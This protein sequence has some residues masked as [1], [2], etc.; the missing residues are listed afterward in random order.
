[1]SFSMI[2]GNVRSAGVLDVSLT[3]ASVNANTLAEQTFTVPG[4]QTGDFVYVTANISTAVAI[5][6]ARVSAADTLAIRF[7]NA[8]GAGVVPTAGT[9][10]V[11]VVRPGSLPAGFQP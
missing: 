3:P 9:Y 1:M 2:T 6:G 10:R 4:L 8:T 5:I 11:F 7:S